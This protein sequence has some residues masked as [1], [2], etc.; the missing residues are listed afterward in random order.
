[1]IHP[2]YLTQG[3]TIGITCP[4]GY[5][6]ADRIKFAVDHLQSIGYKIVVG[7]TVGSEYHYF[8]GN[9]DAR[10]QDRQCMLD[11]DG[12]DAILMGRG[13]YGTSRIID[14]LDF[15]RF[16]NKPKWICGFS[17]ITAVSYTHLDVYKRQLYYL[18]VGKTVYGLQTL[19]P[20]G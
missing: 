5:V 16:K 8:S 17:D 10:L 20:P 9:D 2:P 13:G 18:S 15:T 4:A 3:S 11:D 6:S 12:I 7:S 19:H 14:R 1:M